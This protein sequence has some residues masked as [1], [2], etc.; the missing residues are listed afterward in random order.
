VFSVQQVPAAR[1]R[2]GLLVVQL[3]PG[4]EPTTAVSRPSQPP[5][6][7]AFAAANPA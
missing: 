4:P 1:Q 7:L 3:N 5:R 2:T 6:N